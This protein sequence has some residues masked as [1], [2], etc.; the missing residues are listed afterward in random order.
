[1]Q[2]KLSRLLSEVNHR[3]YQRLRGAPVHHELGITPM[4]AHM[5]MWIRRTPEATAS[6]YCAH[7]G[8]D[9]GQVAR[10]AGQL[11]AAGWVDRE[12]SPE[13]GRVL[14]MALTQ[15]GHATAARLKETWDA[16]ARASFAGVSAEDCAQ[17]ERILSTLRENLRGMPEP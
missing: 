9:R 10:L 14:C 2:E 13:D 17:L 3:F 7:S 12:P 16:L 6:Q 15:E 4:Q 11:V 8:R 1:M 5:L